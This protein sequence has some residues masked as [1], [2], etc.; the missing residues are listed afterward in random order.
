MSPFAQQS[1]NLDVQQLNDLSV[2]DSSQVVKSDRSNDEVTITKNRRRKQFL[3]QM[4]EK[5]TQSK[6]SFYVG[7]SQTN[8]E[9]D[10]NISDL[11]LIK[12]TP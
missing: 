4:K 1:H 12:G 3:Q 2:A 5:Q 10:K 7:E 6:A 9:V 8:L 11:S